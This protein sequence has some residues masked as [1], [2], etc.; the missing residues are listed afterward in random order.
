MMLGTRR[1]L[2]FD[3]MGRLTDSAYPHG[4][5]KRLGVSRISEIRICNSPRWAVNSPRWAV[6]YPRW[7]VAPPRANVTGS[8]LILAPECDG[9][10]FRPNSESQAGQR[11]VIAALVPDACLLRAERAKDR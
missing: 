5:V 1:L 11:T 7:A 8:W 2:G 3:H 10:G 6:N 9:G 4:P